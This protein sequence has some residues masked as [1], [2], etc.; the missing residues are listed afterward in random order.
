[1][2]P[3]YR[4]LAPLVPWRELVPPVDWS[5][6]FGRQAPLEVE[7]GP[8]NGEYLVRNAQARPERNLI[9][10]ENEWPSANRCLR[11]IAGEGLTNL[12]IILL[13]A[14]PALTRLFSPGSIDHLYGLF[15][16]PW[17]KARH[18]CRRLFDTPFL[19]LANS[20]L[21]EKASLR[22]VT[23]QAFFADWVEEQVPETGF[24]LQR[25][26]L[27]PDFDTKYGRKWKEHRADTFH[28]LLLSKNETLSFPLPEV[29]EMRTHR[30]PHFDP[31][32]FK[33]RDDEGDLTV[34]FKEVV[35]DPER[36]VAMVR[37]LAVE[38]GYRQPLWVKIART[39]EGDWHIGPSS[40]SSIVPTASVQHALDLVRE[41]AVL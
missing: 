24:H 40:G 13:D 38:D 12:K 6:L 41:A 19:R 10:I 29:P 4:C 23:D 1:M 20:R 18:A 15:P 17:P 31:A 21:I 26:P 33:P 11:R 25:R 35:H 34:R 7:L 32:S 16:M 9:G 30:I 3:R 14:R 39:K 5:V 22:V 36:Q 8:G 37:L 27:P 28:E 2:K